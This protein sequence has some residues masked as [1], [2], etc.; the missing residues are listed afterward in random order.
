MAECAQCRAANDESARNCAQ[1]GQSLPRVCPS[2]GT[3][4]MPSAWFCS[5]CGASVNDE[6]LST[7]NARA[8]RIRGFLPKDLAARFLAQGAELHGEQRRVTVLFIDIA[9]S[10]ETTRLL[11]PERMAELLDRLLGLIARVV[12]ELEGSVID[13]AGDGGLCIFGA[14]VAH[15]DDA[16]RA[17]NAALRI[18][19]ALRPIGDSVPF[20][21]SLAV[22]IGIHTG[23]VVVRALGT[24]VRLKYSAVGE[25]VHL[26]QRL[27]AAAVPGEILVSAATQSLAP[28]F[29]F[30][31]PQTFRLK[32]FASDVSAAVLLGE[33]EIA[34]RR[35]IA[36]G[37]M[38]VGREREVDNLRS[39][40]GALENGEGSIVTIVGDAGIGKSRLLAEI[41][42]TL[43]T[44]APW[45]EGRAISYGQ[46]TPYWIIGQQ[47]RRA[48]GISSADSQDG[49]REKL[50]AMILREAGLE[51]SDAIRPF[52]E[53]ALGMTLDESDA[54][55]VQR[56]TGDALQSEIHRAVR[57]LVVQVT[58]RTGVILVFEDAHWIDAASVR[59]IDNLLPLVEEHRVMLILVS[60]GDPEAPSAA[61]L[62]KI[63]TYYPHRHTR[64]RLGPLSRA[65]SVR[66]TQNILETPELPLEI[67][68]FV[69]RKA[70]GVPLFVEE[71][72]RSLVEEGALIRDGDWWRPT[73]A[74]S[75]LRVPATVQGII[76]SRIDRLE[77]PVKRV[78]QIASVVG[79]VF[80][81]P[82]L[83]LVEPTG[84][85]RSRLLIL[86]RHEFVHETRGET[87]N[88]FAF[89]HALIQD[90][91]YQSLLESRKKELHQGVGAALET[92]YPARIGEIRSLLAHH[93]MRGESWDKALRYSIEA[94]DAASELYAHPEART[95]YENALVA[96]ANLPRS[97]ENRQHLVDT[98]VKLVAVS[99][100]AE[101]AETNLARLRRAEPA[102]RELTG[103]SGAAGGDALRLARIHYWM[104][105][106]HHVRGEPRE[107]IGYFRQMLPVAEA[108]G[109]EELAAMPA[110][111][112]GTALTVQGQWG[113]AKGLLGR[114]VGAFERKQNW[115]EWIPFQGYY[116][117]SVAA[118]GDYAGGITEGER[119]LA[120]ARE[121]HNEHGIGVSLILLCVT[122]AMAKDTDHLL[123]TSAAG[124]AASERAGDRLIEYGCRAFQ[125]WALSRAGEHLAAAESMSRSQAVGEGLGP[126][127]ILAD[128]FAVARA[129]MA[130]NAG[131]TR[132][133][134]ELCRDALVVAER[135]GSVFTQGLTH[136]VWAMA[137]AEDSAAEAEA[138]FAKAIDLI[139]SGDGV[140]AAGYVY[141]EWAQLCERQGHT[142]DAVGHFST[143][144]LRYEACGLPD[145]AVKAR[146][147]LSEITSSAR[148]R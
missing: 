20:G 87:Q 98:T 111:V 105:R 120:R 142:E 139:E 47:V 94:G 22:R 118:C 71:L 103:T 55:V 15:E 134:V 21:Q 124:I 24:D 11:G 101:I 25:A 54:A 127:L 109:D 10:T 74:L 145:R 52:V 8:E 102:A 110:A 99:I 133:A 1:C 43:P 75:A 100:D 113:K 33:Q 129:E 62:Q 122:H 46:A 38:L 56:Y 16:D 104:G 121:L 13:F 126:K 131:H 49:A 78:L 42:G 148:A 48:A 50:Q 51:R 5:Q 130:L 137:V 144:A 23:D 28:G 66:I 132:E 125:G 57:E 76:M 79:R 96:V 29:R 117:V 7:A 143:A 85:L 27:Q 92:L 36:T 89:R 141:F 115:P 114:A 64:L 65:D 17:L 59:V 146:A 97:D 138:H 81:E 61:L 53:A 12:F 3:S 95:H 140:L 67:A 136:E 112:I 86:Q 93:F 91:A 123:A 44:S 63:E 80:N 58:T 106:L 14:P 9:Q 37:S 31:S 60:R 45:L 70:E 116:G 73:V 84:A 35:P 41:R 30:G 82:V 77:E 18:Q 4:N 40:L 72:T 83:N 147:R 32:G 34:Q 68:E 107:A 2:C 119:A 19:A 90:V 88:E 39:R 135:I 69:H 26:G 6:S 108:L 128:W